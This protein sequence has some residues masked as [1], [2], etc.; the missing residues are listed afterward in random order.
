MNETADF[1]KAGSY[2]FIFALALLFALEWGP[3]ARG[4]RTQSADPTDVPAATVNKKPIPLRDFNRAYANQLNQMRASGSPINESLARQLGFPKQVLD[5]LVNTELLSQAAESREIGAS[6]KELRD[7]IRKNPDFQKDGKFDGERYRD[8]LRDY[9]KRTDV[10]Y[11]AELRRQLSAQKMLDI[12]DATSVVADDEVKAKYLKDGNRANVAFVRFDPKS[13]AAKVPAPKPAELEA[14]ANANE[15]LLKDNFQKRLLEFQ[16]PERVKARQILIRVGREATTE[17]LA[18]AKKKIEAAKADVAAGKDFAAIAKAVS[19]DTE[20]KD[21]GGDLGV[22]ERIQ[23]PPQLADVVF[24]SAAG[25]V[26]EVVQS[27]LGLHLVKVEEKFAPETKK[28]EDVKSVLAAE[29]FVKAKTIALAKQDAEKALDAAKKKGKSL[30]QL[31]PK[32][33]AA[34]PSAP[35]PASTKLEAQETGEFTSSVPLI[36]QIG[37]APDLAKAAFS[38]TSPGLLPNTFETPDG[39]LIAAVTERKTPSDAEFASQKAQ[40]RVEAIKG[41]QYEMREAFLKSLRASAE[42]ISNDSVIGK[43]GDE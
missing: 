34:A 37:T 30:T 6:D 18:E 17:Q 21:K 29:A 26:T 38:M 25:Q 27:P 23:L 42:V 33:D 15:S 19:E 7:L 16:V 1:R 13:Y 24:R 2:F 20:T 40:L 11:E 39:V 22:V 41:K 5:R 32:A 36:P 3:G 28:F 12:V 43:T 31:F 4:C 35:G 14:W 8:I 10:E 9:Y